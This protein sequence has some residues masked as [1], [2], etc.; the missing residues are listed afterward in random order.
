MPDSSPE[1]GP[2]DASALQR[3]R[4]REPP[5]RVLIL[6]PSALGDVARTVPAVASLTRAFPRARIDWL[7]NRPFAP[8]IAQHPGLHAAI[9]FDRHRRR[10]VPGLLADLRRRRYD[11]AIDLQGLA[12]TG[13]LMAAS[14]ACVRVADRAAREGSWVGANRRVR[15]PPR[16]HAVDRLLTLL[17]AC[18]IEPVADLRLYTARADRDA[19]AAAR[20]AAGV[21]GGFLALAPTARWG[22]KRWPLERFAALARSV[23]AAGRPVLAL[24]G[25]ADREA[26]SEFEAAVRGAGA[27][28][29]A[30]VAAVAPAGVGVLMAHLQAAR[31]FLGNDSAGLHLAVGLGVPTVSL[32]GPTD[33]AAVGPFR[34]GRPAATHAVIRC[35]PPPAATAYRHLGDD[36]R[37]MRRIPSEVVEA[38]VTRM[39]RHVDASDPARPD[40]SAPIVA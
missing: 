36:D 26:K 8:A 32:F 25:P 14:G 21:G 3:L 9:P 31:G 28:P 10:S 37:H 16:E 39:L 38:A 23:A 15:I 18:G 29:A 17:Q 40:A 27:G 11:L 13:L 35:E 1:P 22:C 24:F 30:P 2:A 33:P 20:A 19:A 4:L 6:R 7:V 5:Q 34:G 12:R